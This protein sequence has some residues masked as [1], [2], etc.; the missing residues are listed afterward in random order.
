VKI[1]IV[2]CTY[3]RPQR[4]IVLV[5]ELLTCN[6]LPNSILIVDSSEVSIEDKV[7]IENTNYIKSTRKNQPYQ[8]YLGYLNSSAD[9]LVYLDDD[10][11]LIDAAFLK[12]IH[13]LFISMPHLSGIALNFKDKQ[14]DTSLSLIPSST[15]KSKN[16]ALGKCINNLTGYPD[17]K[18]GEWGMNGNRG[19]QPRLNGGPTQWLSGGAFAAKRINLYQNFNFQLFDLFEQ[20]LGMGEDGVLG[21]TLS[22]QNTLYYYPKLLFYHN[23]LK[24]STYSLDLFKFSK[25]VLF[26]RL[27]LSLE[28]ARLDKRSQLVAYTSYVWYAIWR[29]IGL[30]INLILHYSVSRKSIFKGSLSG[31]LKSF[32]FKYQFIPKLNN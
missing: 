5:Q 15:L 13:E 6:P 21:Y 24:D 2:V 25:R 1:D 23:D 7:I 3:N 12:D 18:E 22:K 17:L 20:G 9:I 27:Y 29:L 30:A 31:F 28:K 10:M 16:S 19:P 26:S 8:R 32:T 14:L 11:E 4:V